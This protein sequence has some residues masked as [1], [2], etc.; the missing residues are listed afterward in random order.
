MPIMVGT[1]LSSCARRSSPKSLV[2][3][4][5]HY[6]STMVAT[7]RKPATLLFALAVSVATFAACDPDECETYSCDLQTIER[8]SAGE[9]SVVTWDGEQMA[10]VDSLARGSDPAPGTCY[11]SFGR[12]SSDTLELGKNYHP[13][14]GELRISVNCTSQDGERMGFT[15][16]VGDLAEPAEESVPVQADVWQGL[17]DA[18]ARETEFSWNGLLTV[19]ESEGTTAE[20]PQLVTDDYRRSV[21][22]DFDES[23]TVTR[24]VDA[25]LYFTLTAD[26]Y[27]HEAD[28]ECERCAMPVPVAIG[29]Q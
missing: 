15:T 17:T 29:G 20:P 8:Q 2:A 4:A 9:G 25:T 18:G 6:C 7:I 24:N 3:H 28:A 5:L 22:F 27:Q 26:D 14:I 19:E 11:A 10:L 12:S 16:K 13:P 21:R 23:S 1:A